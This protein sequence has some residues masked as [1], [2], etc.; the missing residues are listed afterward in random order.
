V[1][2]EVGVHVGEWIEEELKVM[3]SSVRRFDWVLET[4]ES[5]M[6]VPRCNFTLMRGFLARG[7]KVS[8]AGWSSV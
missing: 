4:L 7:R 5:E 3:V 2:L 6:E 1:S 8:L